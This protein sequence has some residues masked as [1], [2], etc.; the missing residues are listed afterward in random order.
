MKQLKLVLLLTL[1]STPIFS[2]QESKPMKEVL[3]EYKFETKSLTLDSL[4]ISYVKEGN[5]NKTLLFLHGLSSNSDAWS[6]NIET[7]SKNYTCIALDLPGYGKSSKPKV[8]YT[9]TFFADV[10]YQFLQ[11]LKLKNVVLVG[12]SMGGQASIKIAVQYPEVI[13]KLILVAPAGLEQFTKTEGDM[14]RNIYTSEMVK[15][16]T[17]EQIRKNYALNFY[18]QPEDVS[19]MI[20]DRINIKSSSDFDAHCE[21]IVKSVSGMID[22][23]VFENLKDINQKTLVIFGK[24]DMLIPNRYF[25]PTLSVEKIGEIAKEQIKSVIVEYIDESGHFV[26]F[27]KPEGINTLINTFVNKTD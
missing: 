23:P 1:I 27:E 17:D 22:D 25:H 16:T 2:Q 24:N 9:P 12:H 11:K 15:Y 18:K 19:K 6:K 13:D 10:V 20:E 5:G 4:D 26:Q 14:I 3:S 7:L 8:D 21:A